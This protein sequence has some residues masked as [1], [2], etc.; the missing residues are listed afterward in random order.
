M[1]MASKNDVCI[2]SIEDFPVPKGVLQEL[3]DKGNSTL[4]VPLLST[5]EWCHCDKIF[6]TLIQP[7]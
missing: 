7:F 1:G 5:L 6:I 4:K 3:L 2:S